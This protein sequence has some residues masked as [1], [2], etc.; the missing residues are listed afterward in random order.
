VF[1]SNGLALE[2]VVA[3]AFV[4]EKGV[5]QGFGREAPVFAGYS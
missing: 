4:Y 1:K 2:D 3:A 5:P